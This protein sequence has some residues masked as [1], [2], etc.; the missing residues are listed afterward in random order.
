MKRE[1]IKYELQVTSK[2]SEETHTLAYK[3]VSL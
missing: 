3:S 2:K 1:C